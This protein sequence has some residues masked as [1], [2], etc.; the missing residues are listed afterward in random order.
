[1]TNHVMP[2]IASYPS[3]L[4]AVNA[5]W[6]GISGA[7]GSPA[8]KDQ[9][10]DTSPAAMAI[11]PFASLTSRFDGR[12]AN[13]HRLANAASMNSVEAPLSRR[14]VAANPLKCARRVNSFAGLPMPRIWR[15]G[16]GVG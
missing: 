4:V 14:T 12:R 11:C 15:G 9:S 13:P 2:M 3:N 5:E 10:I 1:M 8:D 7:F 16:R 6:N